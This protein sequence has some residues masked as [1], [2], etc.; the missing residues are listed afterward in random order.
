MLAVGPDSLDMKSN[1]LSVL[2]EDFP[3]IHC[4]G[5]EHHA[6]VLLVEEVSEEPYAMVTIFWIGIVQ[7]FQN[8]KFLESGLVPATNRRA[9]QRHLIYK[10][11]GITLI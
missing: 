10:T 11:R 9:H 7:F 1:I 8:L 6:Q 2:L 4:Q 5:L 3:Q